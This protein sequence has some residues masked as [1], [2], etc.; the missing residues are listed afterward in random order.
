MRRR[1][2]VVVVFAVVAVAVVA[3]TIVRG[4]AAVSGVG[5]RV[6][7]PA[8]LGLPDDVSTTFSPAAAGSMTVLTDDR[9][10]G[11][12]VVD[13]DGHGVTR[14]VPPTP[15]M[16]RPDGSGVS[17]AD[18]DD[19]VRVTGFDTSGSRTFE[20]DGE[21]GVRGLADDAGAPLPEGD[22]RAVVDTA[23][24][25]DVVLEACVTGDDTF[26]SAVWGIDA[27]T[28]AVSWHRLDDA[29]SCSLR[30]EPVGTGDVVQRRLVS[31]DS[32]ILDAA[33]GRVVRQNDDTQTRVAVVGGAIYTQTDDGLL[34]RS[35]DGGAAEWTVDGCRDDV[36]LDQP[37][38]TVA[39]RSSGPFLVLSCGSRLVA[40]DP[41]TGRS[42]DLPTDAH[43]GDERYVEGSVDT[44]VAP[45]HLFERP[46]SVLDRA[47][48]PV[49]GTV[50]VER[51]G[52]VVT[53]SDALSGKRLWTHE[54]DADDR[55]RVT[56]QAFAPSEA[57]RGAG[58]VV[59]RSV[60]YDQSG[61][62]SS[63]KGS[64]DVRVLDDRTGREVAHTRQRGSWTVRGTTTGDV[65]LL[66]DGDDPVVA[67]VD[68][69]SGD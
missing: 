49:I 40:I 3:A 69:R 21:D 5:V 29:E 4:G 8:D 20:I 52:R 62:S 34:T 55:D 65:L 67:L 33:T 18:A 32:L 39:L 22:V 37:L 17:V 14:E 53:A 2:A 43:A 47:V 42:R 45:S 59:V 48:T 12:A 41:G 38:D 68:R 56:V 27:R 1:K 36:L 50:V 10:A 46:E 11:A 23:S 9:V 19:A 25:D 26:T 64:A 28:G 13:A 63:W 57:R 54:V 44:Q 16:I 35:D 61:D 58:S 66:R 7:G 31:G 24:T 15:V 30:D 60:S 51:S 6:F